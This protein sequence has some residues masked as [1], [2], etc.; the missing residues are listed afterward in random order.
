MRDGTY[1]SR[2][3]ATLAPSEYS[4]RLP[5]LC[6]KLLTIFTML[7]HRA[8]VRPYTSFYNL[9]KSCVFIKQSHPLLKWRLY[10]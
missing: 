9:A 1:P 10:S 8:D 3:F 6:R 7:G 4:G 2:S 5:Y